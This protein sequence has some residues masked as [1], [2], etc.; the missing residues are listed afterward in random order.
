[1]YFQDYMEG[2][3]CFGC[4]TQNKDGLHVQSMWNGEESVC[5]WKP[6]KKYA[7]WKN[8]LNGGIIST[9]IDCHC[10]GTAIADAYKRE[11]RAF[12]SYPEYRYATGSLFVKYLKPTPL[13]SVIELRA[14][15]REVKER[16]TILSCFL[17]ADGIK[18]AEAEVIAIRV[19]DSSK[20]EAENIFK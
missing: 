16:K 15:V 13:D 2:N 5:I 11:K 20:I 3:V 18:T 4:G 19:Y 7:G 12:G 9:L 6:E 17:F 1:M 10:M 14:S 8:L